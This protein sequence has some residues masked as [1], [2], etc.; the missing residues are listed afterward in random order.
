MKKTA[1]IIGLS[2]FLSF[3]FAN[4][5]FTITG[6]NY[7]TE[8]T[9][10]VKTGDKKAKKS[11]HGRIVK[12]Q[13]LYGKSYIPEGWI[14]IKKNGKY[15]YINNQGEIIVPPIYKTIDPFGREFENYAL[16]MN[17]K[18]KFGLID[19][20]GK[21]VV[22]PKCFYFNKSEEEKNWIFICVKEKPFVFK[23]GYLDEN[24][25]E[26][27]P[28]IYD[29]LYDFD[30]E[31]EGLAKVRKDK[32]FGYINRNNEEVIPIVYDVLTEFGV[33]NNDRALVKKDGK[34]GFI[35]KKGEVVVPIKYSLIDYFDE[36][37]NG[38]KMKKVYLDK[39]QGFIDI[40]GNEF[41]SP[42]YD[43]VY[44]RKIADKDYFFPVKDK[45]VGLISPEGEVIVSPKYDKIYKF[46]RYEEKWAMVEIDKKFGIID[47]T[48]KII[49]EPVYSK[50]VFNT[51]IRKEIY[52]LQ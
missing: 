18:G 25:N 13:K 42:V 14:R 37:Y 50:E 35:N 17:K 4:N 45:K 41:I 24:F 31:L 30:A 51:H 28:P 21:E 12:E 52:K 1:L 26:V 3:A 5:T 16:V 47:A 11:K 33:F 7:S 38:I 22:S 49:V 15:G 20:N 19:R 2:I 36:E 29:L 34:Y 32:K 8:D 6:N 40:N 10:N 46:G 48:G 39:Y 44:S 27:I 23:H 43:E 9:G